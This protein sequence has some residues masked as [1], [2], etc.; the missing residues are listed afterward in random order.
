MIIEV[1]HG[2]MRRSFDAAS[3]SYDAFARLQA[4]TRA[5]L[6][7]R[8]AMLRLAPGIAVDLGSGTGAGARALASLYPGATIIAVDFALAMLH[9]ARRHSGV[10]RS[11]FARIGADACA[12]PL[13]DGTVDLIFSNL[14]L[15]WCNPPDPVFAEARRVLKPGGFF[16]FSTFGPMSLS[17]LRS[18]WAAADAHPH[19]H[20]FLDMH[21]LGS[22]LTRAGFVEPV[23][24]VDRSRRAYADPRALMRELKAIG[25]H[26]AAQGRRRGLTGRGAFARMLAAYPAAAS[27]GIEASFEIIYGAA[28]AGEMR[29]PQEFTVA[30]A[31]IRRPRK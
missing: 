17:E 22:A 9:E 19:V 30:A 14:L 18:A 3:G 16:A 1:D 2:A 29:Q 26:N 21:D 28:W 27:G 15:Q 10:L 7:E 6:L 4:E 20:A 13:R 31:S 12:L 24:D 5:E 25:A 11:R 23:L 8:L